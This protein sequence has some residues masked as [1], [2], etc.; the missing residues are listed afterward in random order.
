MGDNV[1]ERKIV[2][3]MVKCCGGSVISHSVIREARTGV[4]FEQDW[5]ESESMH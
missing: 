2:G 1:K 5:K 4:T 3:V